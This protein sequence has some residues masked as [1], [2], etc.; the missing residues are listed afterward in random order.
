[1]RYLVFLSGPQRGARVRIERDVVR[2]GRERTNDVALEDIN[3][4]RRHA[5]LFLHEGAVYIRDLHSTNGT[6]VNG[7]RVE[8]AKL[9]SGDQIEIG[10]TVLLF[11]ERETKS[12]TRSVAFQEGTADEEAHQLRLDPRKSQ[13]LNP[14]EL[15]ARPGAAERLALV[16]RFVS[17]IATVLA[18]AKL[19]E[20]VLESVFRTVRADRGFL[21]LVEPDGRL[22]PAAMRLR[23]PSAPAGE[24]KVS[25]RMTERVLSTG[26][27]ILS[28]DTLHDGRFKDSQAF[29][30]TRVSSFICVPLKSG[31]RILG[32]LYVDTVGMTPPLGEDDLQLLTALALF[33]G[34]QMSNARLYSELLNAARYTDSILRCLRSGVIVTDN[35]GIV[36]QVNESACELLGMAEGDLTGKRFAAIETFAPLWRVMEETQRSGIPCER[37]EVVVTVAGTHVPI[38]ISTSLL[39]DHEN[40]VRGVVAN[41]RNLSVIKKLSEQVR[42]SQ[43]LAALGE[44]AA[45]IA[46]EVRNPLNSIR[47]FAQLLGES[48]REL[49]D[50]QKAAAAA[51]YVDIIISEVDRMNQLVQDLLD[52]S[53]Q[54]ELTMMETDAARLVADVL[55]EM[56]PEL[57]GAGVT[58]ESKLEPN[59]PPVMANAAKLKQV[60]VNLLK[61]ALQAMTPPVAPPERARRL[62]VSV[63]PLEEAGH[64]HAL[65]FSV[66]DTGVG[67]DEKTRSRLFEPFFT[68]R[69]RGTGLG[70]AICRKIVEQHG[71]QIEADT[72]LG[73][74]TTMR[75]T[76]PVR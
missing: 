32:L 47:G 23:D 45:G 9:S 43:H 75:F 37:Q 13:Y 25:R 39:R 10:D 55:R 50:S 7:A 59:L 24:L 35:D 65:E 62:T 66:S 12:V 4:S 30:A 36:R 76:L 2:I 54:R 21:M 26:E 11:E 70:L 18:P 48:I 67:M 1:V 15:A 60:L 71:G 5:E 53:R 22:E 3:S 63:R 29:T 56:D 31:D 73:V 49:R 34:A 40:H 17:E 64:V 42:M 61:N 27:G 69:E 52:F 28:S 51:N 19:S 14:T 44:M 41:F 6:F 8:E 33:A 68:T 74:G 46:H 58:V 16:Y 20:Q 38:G 57:S 72:Q